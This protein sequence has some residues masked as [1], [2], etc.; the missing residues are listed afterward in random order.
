MPK[1]VSKPRVAA[2]AAEATE[3]TG[4]SSG[5]DNTGSAH[6]RTEA[7]VAATANKHK[8]KKKKEPGRN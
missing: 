1:P 8:K 6:P 4:R 7:A 2:V 3:N 5:G